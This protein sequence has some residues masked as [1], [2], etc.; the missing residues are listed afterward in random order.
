MFQIIEKESNF[1]DQVSEYS[2]IRYD[3]SALS[4]NAE[5]ILKQILSD[6][7]IQMMPFGIRSFVHFVFK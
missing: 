4:D 1:Q 6:F 3:E 7:S 2:M 5:K